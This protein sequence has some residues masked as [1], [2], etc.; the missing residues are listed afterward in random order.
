MTS[1]FIF[2]LSKLFA[3]KVS[4]RPFEDKTKDLSLQQFFP[5][6]SSKKIDGHLSGL[7]KYVRFC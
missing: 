5:I 1:L 2:G 7:G 3:L 6:S 4:A